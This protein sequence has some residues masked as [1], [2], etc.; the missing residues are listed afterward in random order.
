M[1]QQKAITAIGRRKASTARVSLTPASGDAVLMKVNGR[2]FEE[3]FPKGPI[4]L[5]V[6]KPLTLTERKGSYSVSVNVKGG[7]VA[8]QAGAVAHG[9]SRA[10][11][12]AEPEL[13][14]VLKKAGCLTR[15]SREVE[16]KKA[17]KHKARKSTQFSKR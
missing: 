7:G 13:R 17:G 15:D 3:F 11:E 14:P 1:A 9:I 5:V 16:R 2:E 4:Q 8:G 12:K 10:L 6:L